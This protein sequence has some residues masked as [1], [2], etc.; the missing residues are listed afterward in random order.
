MCMSRINQEL[1]E[2]GAAFSFLFSSSQAHKAVN[3]TIRQI[4]KQ[5]SKI[6]AQDHVI[7]TE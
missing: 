5:E 6:T 7:T 1:K 4:R 3:V 2:R